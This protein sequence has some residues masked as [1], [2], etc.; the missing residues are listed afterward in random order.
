MSA[1]K[2]TPPEVV[3]LRVN[4]RVVTVPVGT[5]VA[6]ALGAEGVP[7]SRVDLGGRPRGPVCGM[8]VCFECRATVDGVPDVLTCLAPCREGQEV[9]TD[10]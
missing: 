5:T 7:V 6:A 10:A 1:S 2:S 4:G 8:G 9:V 3:T